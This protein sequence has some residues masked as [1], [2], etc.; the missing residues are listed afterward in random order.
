MKGIVFTE[1]IEMVEAT[2]GLEVADKMLAPEGLSSNGVY[3]SV[4]TYDDKDMGVLLSRLGAATGMA[5]GDLQRAFG[6]YLFGSFVRGYADMLKG[7]ESTFGLLSRLDDFIHPEVQ[8]LY[9]D[10]T[11]PGFEVTH[12]DD[13]RLEMYY[14]SARKMPEFAEGL[15]QAAAKH[16]GETVSVQWRILD[17]EE[18]VFKFQVEK[19]A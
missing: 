18:G 7:F 9:P 1:L 2:F 5:G 14:R 12:R 8:R 13:V 19:S 15:I 4:G 10:A 6:G 3:T 16:F 17:A 11:L